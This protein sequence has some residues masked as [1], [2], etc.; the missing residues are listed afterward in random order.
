MDPAPTATEPTANAVLQWG[1]SASQERH[2]GKK[3]QRSA[4]LCKDHVVTRPEEMA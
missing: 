2:S 4:G 1:G 3:N